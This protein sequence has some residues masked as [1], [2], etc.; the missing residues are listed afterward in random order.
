MK[1]VD[2]PRHCLRTR[3]ARCALAV[4]FV[5]ACADAQS[6]DQMR[7]QKTA[8]E[9][10]LEQQMHAAVQ[11]GRMTP[12]QALAH[13]GPLIE[14]N[15]QQYRS[16]DPRPPDTAALN[17]K[18][19]QAGME[20]RSTGGRKDLS[21]K[22]INADVDAVP[23][24]KATGMAPKGAQQQQAQQIIRDHVGASGKENEAKIVDTG[25]DATYWKDS[26][27]AGEA[28]KRDDPDA[29]KNPGS[30]A[31][32]RNPG[33]YRKDEAGY[34]SDLRGKT[35]EARTTGDLKTEAKGLVKAESSSAVGPLVIKTDERGNVVTD[36]DTGR[37]VLERSSLMPRSPTE[38][39]TLDTAKALTDYK[40]G[41][42]AGLYEPG[43]TKAQ[44]NEAAQAFDKNVQQ[45]MDD[46]QTRADT[47]SGV[48]DGIRTDLQKG[49]ESSPDPAIRKLG[50]TVAQERDNIQKTGDETGK[51]ID[52]LIDKAPAA[53]RYT[54]GYDA[55]KPP[56][57]S[58]AAAGTPVAGQNVTSITRPSGNTTTVTTDTGL[59]GKKT[60]T[61][62]ST[63]F[64]SK[65]TALTT[66]TQQKPDGTTV[67]TRTES[68]LSGDQTQTR[69][70][71]TGPDG[72][73]T[74]TDQSSL[75]RPGGDRTTVTTTTDSKGDTTIRA[76]RDWNAGGGARGTTYTSVDSKGQET[77]GEKDVS[78][79]GTQSQD[80][81]ATRD[82]DGNLVSSQQ[83]TSMTRP[84]G[85]VQTIT[86]S[87]KDG[88]DT[89]G[90]RNTTGLATD[91]GGTKVTSRDIT[92]G[93]VLTTDSRSQS[94]EATT[95]TPGSDNKTTVRTSSSTTDTR[96]GDTTI[97]REQS[98]KGS[99]EKSWAD[100]QDKPKPTG[101]QGTVKLVDIR[102][103]IVK[104]Q[105]I[106]HKGASG[107]TVTDG[108]TD[109]SGKIDARLGSVKVEQ[110]TTVTMDQQGNL[111]GAAQV[112]AE[113]NAAKLTAEGKAIQQV[114]DV[115]RAELAAKGDVTLGA[116][117]KVKAGA[118]A[119]PDGVK[120]DLEASAFAG[121][122]AKGN[123]TAT[124]NLNSSLGIKLT[125][126]G[127]GEV[128]AGV[129]GGASADVEA[130][131]TKIK[132]GAG[133]NL[134]TGVG[135]G[136]KASFEVDAEGLITWRN[137]DADK[138]FANRADIKAGIIAAIKSGEMELPPGKKFGDL[139]PEINERADWLYNHPPYDKD[140]NKMDPSK[141]VMGVLGFVPKPPADQVAS[142]PPADDGKTKDALDQSD[143]SD[144]SDTSDQTD[145]DKADDS[146]DGSDDATTASD[147][148]PAS[149]DD[150]AGALGAL[151]DDTAAAIQAA[152]DQS[153]DE[154]TDD[155]QDDTTDYVPPAPTPRW[156]P[157]QLQ[158]HNW[159][160]NNLA[161]HITDDI[162]DLQDKINATHD[163][164][165]KKRLQDEID[166]KRKD[167]EDVQSI[168]NENNDLLA[169]QGVGPSGQTFIGQGGNTA[170]ETTVLLTNAASQAQSNVN[171]LQGQIDD[172]QNGGGW[173]DPDKLQDLLDQLQKEK[174]RLAGINNQLGVGQDD[175][176]DSGDGSGGYDP[177][178]D[179]DDAPPPDDD[180]YAAAGDI[181]DQ[182]WDNDPSQR[183][184]QDAGSGDDGGSAIDQGAI[185]G[186]NVGDEARDRDLHGATPGDH[187]GRDD[188]STSTG[189]PTNPFDA[190]DDTVDQISG[191]ARGVNQA[192]DQADDL[193][194]RI[195]NGKPPS[196]GGGTDDDG[197]TGGGIPP[198]TQVAQ[199]TG[200]G[201]GGGRPPGMGGGTSTNG[202]DNG[203]GSGGGGGNGGKPPSGGG[204]GTST[205]GGGGD[206]TVVVTQTGT[207][208]P[209][210]GGTTGA[211]AAGPGGSS[212]ASGS[213]GYSAAPQDQTIDGTA[214]LAGRT[215][216]GVR[217]TLNYD[218]YSIPDEFQIVYGGGAVATTGNTSGAGVLNGNGSGN[219]PIVTIRVITRDT[220]TSW[221]WSA[222]VEYTVQ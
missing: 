212:G 165:E 198:G 126:K 221:N 68:T 23:V 86:S 11:S 167:L 125:A 204:T 101:P 135:A 18:L 193:V 108:G 46:I 141:A 75:A 140:G 119:G 139:L 200:G 179:T 131:W 77:K 214:A 163:S 120:A 5:A 186:D 106:V 172:L 199:G 159:N 111:K 89:L 190:L 79:G 217:V 33:Q 3:S 152:I 124:M 149:K 43:A 122:K 188:S 30:L 65:D 94:T 175:G 50:E 35:E 36:K 182:V 48:R 34:I 173:V 110:S 14:A 8:Q 93:G 32:T 9:Q 96:V 6:L 80:A 181:Q 191:T 219:S 207:A 37:P 153:P 174:D 158:N 56:A 99:V 117:G 107:G 151:D 58:A 129:G 76:D 148:S 85:S 78:S 145:S 10:A 38:Q 195:R 160:L 128:S 209:G 203:G 187:T 202:G 121:F 44:Q 116:D 196:Q 53:T 74:T 208:Q 70:V 72:K 118:Q 185:G 16:A 45:R 171:N 39:R 90:V 112:T 66:T 137:P 20:L 19:G 169:Q 82:K 155:V 143:Q 24:T 103:D 133:A 192:V 154:P 150:L 123:A 28:A 132:L 26:T 176:S 142:I 97:K 1:F 170:D 84:D 67:K 49:Y 102:N 205:N 21:P 215:V 31:E 4:W 12:D 55:N 164:S 194:D 115:G 156:T 95:Q 60:I 201:T 189:A 178:A 52:E 83:S 51:K 197:S 218:A 63:S 29:F 114:G 134:T 64:T 71:K 113:A 100:G 180:Q 61:A 13:Y 25:K 105:S 81:S 59:D 54:G 42:E 168:V 91:P 7:Q 104:E 62:E 73:V 88:K 92:S 213:G 146:G 216:T 210:A 166:K 22:D 177:N 130:S 136:G 98:I 87:T 161:G 157:A 40:T 57:S 222:R 47:K 220:S 184:A 183:G 138:E 17:T 2:K 206:D 211:G 144:P 15:R 147:A 27:P 109:L 127:E 41:P 162:K 69:T